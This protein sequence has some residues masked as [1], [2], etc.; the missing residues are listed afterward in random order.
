[1]KVY[2]F[3]V[4]FFCS[5]SATIGQDIKILSL[6]QEHIAYAPK[7][8]YVSD[9]VDDRKVKD[10][11]GFLRNKGQ[12]KTKLNFRD[13]A[14]QTLKLFIARN[15]TQDKSKQPVIMH[16]SKLDFIVKN[17]NPDNSSSASAEVSFAFYAG[18]RKLLEMTGAGSQTSDTGSLTFV[19][20]YVRK[21]VEN[22]ITK[23]DEWW[24]KNGAKI[25]TAA[26]V[27][28][29]ATIG[30]TTTKT[31]CIVYSIHRPLEIHD[32]T[33]S[34]TGE[35]MELASTMSAIS[36]QSGGQTKNG[37]IVIDVVFTPYFSKPSSWFKEQ[38]K[39]PRVLAHE[40]THFSIMAIKACEL[41]AKINAT[42]FQ[43]DSYDKQIEELFRQY[44]NAAN[45]EEAMFDEE[46]NH[47]TIAD[48]EK[49]WER[50]V[51]DKVKAA[52]CY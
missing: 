4:A 2:F 15:V 17:D 3:F 19:E 38:G 9:V 27:K 22:D 52:G 49:A 25:P 45:E 46:T 36:M 24:G 43:K 20:A 32:F 23:F 44:V 29:N 42:V 50:K 8:F 35:G 11:V 10:S 28:V 40:Q 18:D 14:A 47:N 37:Q 16:I 31:D 6:K 12:K 13:G 30:K 33:G 26:T 41:V 34:P 21:A 39:N 7:N 5:L 51:N 1:M 48:K